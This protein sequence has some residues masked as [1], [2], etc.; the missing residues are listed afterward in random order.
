M[1]A[2]T[3]TIRMLLVL[4]LAGYLLIPVAVDKSLIVCFSP[5]HPVA[6]EIAGKEC[7]PVVSPCCESE[8]CGASEFEHY[9]CE[10]CVDLNLSYTTIHKR[11]ENAESLP[12]PVERWR[13]A[14]LAAIHSGGLDF[15]TEFN[16]P[17]Y[18]RPPAPDSAALSTT[19]L[20]I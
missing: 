7:R 20:L 15:T 10:P 4:M 6:L 8:C 19:V 12:S 11:R 2:K 14:S 9:R 18:L 5:G 3:T 1:H 13:I 16:H 17:L